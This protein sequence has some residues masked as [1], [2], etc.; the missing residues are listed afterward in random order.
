MQEVEQFIQS[1]GGTIIENRVEAL[2]YVSASIPKNR[3][4]EVVNNYLVTYISLKGEEEPLNLATKSITRMRTASNPVNLG[5]YGLSGKGVSM[6][7]GDNYS[8]VHHVDLRDRVINYVPA[9]YNYH[10]L[11][12]SGIAGGAGIMDI[13]GR[14]AA[15]EAILSSHYFSEVLNATPSIYKSNNV[16]V[17]N[18]SYSARAGNCEYTGTYDN[19]SASVDALSNNYSE[20]LHVFASA[21]N[22]R[23]D[24]APYPVGFGTV[25]GGYQVSKNGL[26]V[27]SCNKEFVNA[28]TGS[29]GPVLDGRLKPEISTVGIG[30]YSTTYTEDYVYALGTSMASPNV[31]GGAAL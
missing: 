20:V 2:G 11:H 16:T 12:I 25:A 5:G 15:P 6:G 23:F 8:G 13:K 29:R 30:I 18:N 3:F 14:G 24:C 26:V 7:I 4:Y 21:N 1:V 27:T 28:E 9:P 19:L 31:A 22:G 17:T 10:G